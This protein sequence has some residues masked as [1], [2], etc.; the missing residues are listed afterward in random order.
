MNGDEI[1]ALRLRY[2]LTQ[3]QVA[4]AAGLRQPALS[5]ME[6]G[7][8]GS[9]AAFERVR[10]AILATVRPSEVLDDRVRAAVRVTLGSYGA[11]NIRV[12]GSVARG[13]D[14]PG[15]DLDLIAEFPRTLDLFELMEAESAIEAMVG[16]PV[17]IVSDTPRTVFA[18]KRAKAE[19]VPL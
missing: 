15:S 13:A 8:R 16:V 2:G 1:R 4:H 10:S 7:R 3:A 9:V 19:A 14:G 11:T 12:F 5:A 6:N 17:D 18:L